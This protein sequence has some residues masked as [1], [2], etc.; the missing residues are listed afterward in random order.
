M[1]DMLWLLTAMED[2]RV[3]RQRYGPG[4]P[5]RGRHRGQVV[6]RSL[7]VNGGEECACI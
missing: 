1:V 3:G 5:T 6:G 7:I 4:K 2:G